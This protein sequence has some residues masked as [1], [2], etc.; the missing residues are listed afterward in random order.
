MNQ[1]LGKILL[2]GLLGLSSACAPGRGDSNQDPGGTGIKDQGVREIDQISAKAP[3]DQYGTVY[4]WVTDCGANGV[5]IAGQQVDIYINRGVKK[6]VTTSENGYFS[7]SYVPIGQFAFSI[8]K[9]GYL[10]VEGSDELLKTVLGDGQPTSNSSKSMNKI[11]LL[12]QNG[13]L[14]VWVPLGGDTGHNKGVN[15]GGLSILM[16]TPSYFSLSETAAPGTLP[17]PK[18]MVLLSAVTDLE[19][20]IATFDVPDLSKIIPAKDWGTDYKV[21]FISGPIGDFLPA[22]ETKTGKELLDAGRMSSDGVYYI[23]FGLKPLALNN[24][25]SIQLVSST[26]VT[27][28]SPKVLKGK[29]VQPIGPRDPIILTFNKPVNKDTVQVTVKSDYPHQVDQRV[30]PSI[31]QVSSKKADGADNGP[32]NI[33]NA[34]SRRVISSSDIVFD[35]NTPRFED[36]KF[37]EDAVGLIYN[38]TINKGINVSVASGPEGSPIGNILILTPATGKTW[39][40]EGAERLIGI[41]VVAAKVSGGVKTPEYLHIDG[42]FF[43]MPKDLQKLEANKIIFQRSVLPSSKMN[44]VNLD[45]YYDSIIIMFNQPVSAYGS[46]ATVDAADALNRVGIKFCMNNADYSGDPAG[47]TVTADGE[48]TLDPGECPKDEDDLTFRLKDSDVA[49]WFEMIPAFGSA[50]TVHGFSRYYQFFVQRNPGAPMTGINPSDVSKNDYPWPVFSNRRV[51]LNGTDVV[52]ARWIVLPGLLDKG[53]DFNKANAKPALTSFNIKLYPNPIVGGDFWG[54]TSGARKLVTNLN[55]E[56]FVV[57]PLKI[58]V[59]MADSNPNAVLTRKPVATSGG[60][61]HAPNN[62]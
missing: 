62:Q 58:E 16:Q 8:K 2:A 7:M 22:N 38:K 35:D 12:P 40:P 57:G 33:P 48:L 19:T 59:N 9:E 11:C 18:G 49:P 42:G 60:R 24:Q 10:P 25:S 32:L 34:S 17:T 46:R 36:E 51:S 53:F 23:G 29:S 15:A 14:G 13:K 54:H 37:P 31:L 3:V 43:V 44:G 61:I 30:P 1:N 28:N 55:D 4:G 39:G 6:S 50:E 26:I 56:P 41:D 52:D 21:T 47:R 20:K 5:P 45:S 27:N